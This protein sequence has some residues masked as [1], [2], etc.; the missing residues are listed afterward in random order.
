MAIFSCEVTMTW[1]NVNTLWTESPKTDKD[2]RI[3]KNYNKLILRL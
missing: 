1:P 2:T 3:Q